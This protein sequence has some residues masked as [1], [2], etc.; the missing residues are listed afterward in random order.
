MSRRSC[1]RPASG[2]LPLAAGVPSGTSPP[3]AALPGGDAFAQRPPMRFHWLVSAERSCG[4][5]SRSSM[6]RRSSG[7]LP[8]AASVPGGRPAPCASACSRPCAF[9]AATVTA[10]SVP[11][12]AERSG[13]VCSPVVTSG[14]SCGGGGSMGG[15]GAATPSAPSLETESSFCSPPAAAASTAAIV[16]AK[17]PSPS[18]ALDAGWGASIVGGERPT[19]ATPSVVVTTCVLRS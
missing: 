12:S 1:A 7:R 14:A 4:A 9:E 11:A 6:P 13:R 16:S 18:P 19:W 5:M 17:D 3:A 15:A 10:S 2:R 8:F